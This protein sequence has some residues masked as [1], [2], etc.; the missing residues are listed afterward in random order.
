[1]LADGTD[2]QK[3]AAAKACRLAVSQ[4]DQSIIDQFKES[5]T[6]PLLVAA[7]ND[8]T[9]SED[10][11]CECAWALTNIA[12]G[13]SCHTA[14]VME[15]GAG[16]ALIRLMGHEKDTVAE[17]SVWALSNIAGIARSRGTR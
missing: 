9:S 10:L 11:L 7:L 15:A 8:V 1:L 3:C 4:D 13:E 12:S 6:F 14:A 5:G 16:P 2:D 17:Q